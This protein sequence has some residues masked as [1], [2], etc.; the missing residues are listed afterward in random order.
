[1]GVRPEWGSPVAWRR[2][3]RSADQGNCLEVA[4]AR[5]SVLVRDSRDQSGPV[6]EL[7]IDEW[8]QLVR[9]IQSDD[10]HYR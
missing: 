10:L 7:S 2:S 4:E 5:A 9:R 3:T 6:L 8:R 1:M